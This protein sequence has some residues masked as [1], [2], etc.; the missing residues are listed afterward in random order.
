MP[1]FGGKQRIAPQIADL[2]P[3]HGHYVEPFAGG[4]SV[5]F[6]KP[7]A[8]LE[9]VNDLDGDIVTFWR[10]LRERPDDLIRVCALTPHSRV[11][12]T[13]SRDRDGSDELEQARRV[14][15]GLTQGRSGQLMRTGW[16]HYIQPA[17]TSIGVPGHLEAYVDRMAAAA[18]RLHHVSLECRPALDVIADYGRDRDTLLYIDPPYPSQVRGGRHATSSYQVEM[19]GAR[20]HV[21]LLEVLGTVHAAVAISGYPNPLYSE[22]LSGWNRTEI[23]AFTGNGPK[24]T[25]E[26][27]VRTEAVWT[28]YEPTPTLFSDEAVECLA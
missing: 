10:V 23:R 6:A 3:D 14:W 15:V 1:Y 16:R 11:E 9:T 22:M 19:K 21:E 2:F 25:A 17:G 20:Q 27:G 5:L 18:A 13:A 8:R 24:A 4:L 26:S 12:H 28:N 7:P